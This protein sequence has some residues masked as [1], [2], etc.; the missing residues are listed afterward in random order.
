MAVLIVVYVILC[1]WHIIRL[2]IKMRQG[3]KL[4]FLQFFVSIILSPLIMMVLI[5]KFCKRRYY[6]NKPMPVPKKYKKYL[7]KDTVMHNHTS[8]SLA[9]YN[10]RFDKKITLE[11]VYGKKYVDSLSP[12][13]IANFDKCEDSISYEANLLDDMMSRICTAFVQ[14]RDTDDFSGFDNYLSDDVVLIL[15]NKGKIV[16][17]NGFISYW[18]DYRMRRMKDKIILHTT[19]KTCCLYERVAILDRPRRYSPMYLLFS[20]ENDKIARAVYVPNPF[21]DNLLI[22]YC[23]LDRPPFSWSLLDKS[24]REGTKISS[25]YYQIPCLNCGKLSE[26]LLWFRV[27]IRIVDRE[28]VG[29]LS[30]CPDCIEQVEFKPDGKVRFDMETVKIMDRKE[31]DSNRDLLSVLNYTREQVSS[32]NGCIIQEHYDEILLYLA[33]DLEVDEEL[34][35]RNLYFCSSF[36]DME[37]KGSE[38]IKSTFVNKENDNALWKQAVPIYFALAEK[39]NAEAYNYLGGIFQTNERLRDK[40]FKLGMECGS[41]FAAYNLACVTN[42]MADKFSYYLWVANHSENLDDTDDNYLL[43]IVYLNLAIMLHQGMGIMQDKEEAEKWYRKARAIGTNSAI[44]DKDRL[45][46]LQ[47]LAR[48]TNNL[49]VL[50]YEKQMPLE[51]IKM[52]CEFGFHNPSNTNF[53]RLIFEG[54]SNVQIMLSLIGVLHMDMVHAY[55][56]MKKDKCVEE[57][58]FNNLLIALRDLKWNEDFILDDFRPRKIGIETESSVLWL[59]ARPHDQRL[60]DVTIIHRIRKKQ[61]PPSIFQYITLPFTH[62]AIWEA[63]LLK[64][65]YRLIGMRGNGKREARIF[66]NVYND[67]DTM[68]SVEDQ[69]GIR[70][71]WSSK[72]LPLV[73]LLDDSAIVTHCWFDGSRGL[74]QVSCKVLYDKIN[75]RIVSFEMLNEKI[76]YTISRM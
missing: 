43:C 65:T 6:K 69:I 61:F 56:D 76:L 47:T 5:Y 46:L 38:V 39:G 52:F 8:M 28:Y 13:E 55:T 58:I 53:T 16:G 23:G 63:Y 31:K 19:V 42:N 70:D 21:Y 18:K 7:K 44:K 66:L 10:Y 37:I 12:D 40:Y 74:L 57:A 36:D 14:A 35:E 60:G 54:A 22:P 33:S 27:K 9:E 45:Y 64:Q 30:I 71:I 49:G 50:L 73:Q 75:M 48:A 15:Y 72:L 67:I 59:Y 25:K 41:V 3:L 2:F 17:K 29:D 24:I 1:L 62:E 4:S 51:S 68:G 26:D 34:D 20:L 32:Y 11:D